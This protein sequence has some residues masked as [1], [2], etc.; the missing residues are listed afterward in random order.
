VQNLKIIKINNNKKS[1]IYI[2]RNL[3]TKIKQKILLKINILL[4]IKYKLKVKIKTK[5]LKLFLINIILYFKYLL[6]SLE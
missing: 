2:N 5:L 4:K 6:I 3:L 1:L